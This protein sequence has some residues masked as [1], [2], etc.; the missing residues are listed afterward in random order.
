M[1]PMDAGRPNKLGS[2][3]REQMRYFRDFKRDEFK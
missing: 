1:L 3:L 2:W